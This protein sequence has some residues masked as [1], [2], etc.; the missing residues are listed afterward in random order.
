[1]I[2]LAKSGQ[3]PKKKL[4]QSGHNGLYCKYKTLP[5]ASCSM[6]PTRY[7]HPMQPFFLSHIHPKHWHF[8]ENTFELV[9]PILVACPSGSMGNG[10]TG[11]GD[12][13]RTAKITKYNCLISV[14]GK[15]SSSGVIGLVPVCLYF[16]M[17][18]Q[19]DI[20]TVAWDRMPN[21]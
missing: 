11:A 2:F 6:S 19:K 18:Y 10:V 12:P 1:L 21:F 13:V 20:F 7:C 4:G 14:S 8:Q 9:D 15:A 5:A 3:P 17:I 16:L